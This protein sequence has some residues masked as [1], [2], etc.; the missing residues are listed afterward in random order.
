MAVHEHTLS[1]TPPLPSCLVQRQLSLQVALGLRVDFEVGF[2][3][4]NDSS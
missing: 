1:L 4:G 2:G 3:T